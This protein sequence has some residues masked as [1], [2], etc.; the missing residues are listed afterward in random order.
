MYISLMTVL[1]TQSV[2]FKHCVVWVFFK[3]T[4]AN[5]AGLVARKSYSFAVLHGGKKRTSFSHVLK[6]GAVAHTHPRC[7]LSATSRLQS[8]ACR[9]CASV[10][11]RRWFPSPGDHNHRTNVSKNLKKWK[12]KKKPKPVPRFVF[13]C[14]WQF[15]RNCNCIISS[16]NSMW[17]SLLSSI[18]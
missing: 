13:F 5:R 2:R 15:L 11:R 18:S 6:T 7:I 14:F 1:K 10:A 3:M 16:W 17:A 9:G 4:L 8:N 12:K